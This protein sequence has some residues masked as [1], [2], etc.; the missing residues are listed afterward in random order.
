MKLYVAMLAAAMAQGAAGPEIADVK[1]V[2]VLPMANG[3]DQFLAIRLTTDNVLQ[4][5]TDA[6]RADSILTDRIGPAL[7]AKLEE[8]YAPKA[9]PPDPTKDSDKDAMSAPAKHIVPTSHARG[10]IFLVDR[11]TRNV[12]WSLYVLPKNTSPGEMNHVAERIA[13]KLSKDLKGK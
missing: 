7:D 10:T 6:Q 2:Y 4:V 8:L 1:T 3:L 13:G 9:P 11:K 5:V 12:L